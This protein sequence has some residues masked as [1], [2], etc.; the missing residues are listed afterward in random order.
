MLGRDLTLVLRNSDHEVFE[1][2]IEELDITKIDQLYKM[3]KE[4]R[5]DTIINC[6]AYTQVDKAEEEPEKALLINGFGV[7]NLALVCK[8]FDIDLCHISTDYVFNGKKEGPYTP[9]D[10]TDPLNVYGHSKLAG[11]KYIQWIWSKFFIIRTSWLYGRRGNDF[12]YTIM[13]LAGH[14]REIKVVEDQV[15]SP[16]WTVTLSE[17]ISR[18]V[19]T[20]RYG[21][22]HATDEVEE[23]ISW[24]EFALE[25]IKLAGLKTMV[26]PIKTEDFPRP[27]KRPKNSVLDIT[28]LKL[29]LNERLSFW[30]KSLQ[31]YLSKL[32]I[33]K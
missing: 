33:S 29:T 2:D 23:G 27:A 7:Q 30:Q 31:R 17:V 4:L 14:N 16:T 1:T 28:M 12:V 10:N 20:K 6:A 32:E 22:Y 26:I 9:F 11:E 5:P 3:S 18:L 25:I 19:K 13:K 24:Y 8:E 15:G 21:I